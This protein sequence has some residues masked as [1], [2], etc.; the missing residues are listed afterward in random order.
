MNKTFKLYGIIFIIVMVVLV[1][2]EMSKAEVIDWRKNYQT[3]EKS[4]FGLYIFDQEAPK[5]LNNKLKKVALSPYDYYQDNKKYE[6]HNILLIEQDID[7]ESWKKIKNMVNLGSDVLVISDN[8]FP[9][10]IESMDLHLSRV[11][12]EDINTL[13]FTDK[14]LKNDSLILDKFPTRQGFTYVS[15]DVEILSTTDTFDEIGANFIKFKSGKGH[16]YFH[17]EPLFLTNY[18]LL[19]SKNSKYLENVFSYLPDRKTMWFTADS[20]ESGSASSPLSF[21]LANAP[22]R[23]AWY[24]LLIGLLIFIFFQAKRKQRIIP[25]LKPLEN[26][27]V[28]FVKSIGNLYLQEGDFHD[29]MAKKAQYFLHKVRLDLFLDTKILDDKFAK[30]L[31]LKTGKNLVKIEEAIV[32]INKAQDPYAQVQKEDLIK[33]NNILDD[34]L[35]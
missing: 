12:F 7:A 29:M 13:K 22:L 26:K 35:G 14:N 28:E 34:I 2:L 21:I 18:Y 17:S 32:L 31:Q 1:L 27:S 23:Y 9:D 4:P 3:K 6:P 5:L 15:E 16:I 24:L 30:K 11:N 8:S 10:P 25:I 33:M 19:S 20:R